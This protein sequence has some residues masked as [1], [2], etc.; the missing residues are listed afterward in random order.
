MGE[1]VRERNYTINDNF[2]WDFAETSGL[3]RDFKY[4]L[5][6]EWQWVF[7]WIYKGVGGDFKKRTGWLEICKGRWLT[8]ILEVEPEIFAINT[9]SWLIYS[10]TQ[11]ALRCHI[12]HIKLWIT[13]PTSQ[14]MQNRTE[15]RSESSDWIIFDIVTYYDLFIHLLLATL[16]FHSHPKWS[17][18]DHLRQ[19]VR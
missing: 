10:D 2:V 4:V 11:E 8:M 15:Y 6:H 1:T 19:N 7:F 13:Y 17:C 5:I 3:P 9:L 16:S 14:E 12:I 18:R